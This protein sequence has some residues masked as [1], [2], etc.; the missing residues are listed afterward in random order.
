MSVENLGREVVSLRVVK[1]KMNKVIR[2]QISKPGA[3]TRV[4]TEE[5]GFIRVMEYLEK[6]QVRLSELLAELS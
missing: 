5:D 4:S 1:G 2:E 3:S 6:K